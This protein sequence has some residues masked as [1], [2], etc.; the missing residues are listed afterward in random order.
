M[1]ADRAKLDR[2]TERL[3]FLVGEQ[4]RTKRPGVHAIDAAFRRGDPTMLALLLREFGD[5]HQSTTLV[6]YLKLLEA[7]D[8]DQFADFAMPVQGRTLAFAR[9]HGC[10]LAVLTIE[11]DRPLALEVVARSLGADSFSHYGGFPNDVNRITSDIAAA[12]RLAFDGTSGL[13]V[14]LYHLDRSTTLTEAWWSLD[15]RKAHLLLATIG[16][17]LVRKRERY[18][19]KDYDAIL[20][21]VEERREAVP[22]AY[23][24]QFD[25]DH[26]FTLADILSRGQTATIANGPPASKR[27]PSS[28]PI[29]RSCHTSRASEA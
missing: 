28:K 2:L 9:Q 17:E 22:S 18:L 8:F 15:D 24:F 20:S 13:I 6:E 5:T 19:C 10:V 1:I 3:G 14:K 25:A 23:R 7:L 16:N 26:R 29:S 11:P 21:L 12:R 4:E 27:G